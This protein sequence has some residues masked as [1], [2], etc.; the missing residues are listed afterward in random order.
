MSE[1]SLQRVGFMLVTSWEEVS[2]MVG[3]VKTRSE[4]FKVFLACTHFLTQSTWAYEC[5][6]GA[7][8][9]RC[10]RYWEQLGGGGGQASKQTPLV[11]AHR[12]LEQV[13]RTQ[14][15]QEEGPEHPRQLGRLGCL[16]G[17]RG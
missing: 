15:F 5:Y 4:L 1:K 11:W 9:Q 10:I 8:G 2:H 3:K 7:G 6:L 12:I 16:G 17:G 14:Y 13:Q